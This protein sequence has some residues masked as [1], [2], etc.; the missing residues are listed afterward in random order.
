MSGADTVA[1]RDGGE[2]LHVDAKEAGE[3]ARLHF[4][5]LRKLRG[6]VGH[7]TV[8][9]AQLLAQGRWQRGSDVAVVRERSGQGLRR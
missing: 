6:Y 9:L 7:R 1:V 4:A 5:Q 2:P 8:V 3:R